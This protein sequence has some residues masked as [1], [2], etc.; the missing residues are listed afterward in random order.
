M[1][2]IIL[3]LSSVYKSILPV[4]HKHLTDYRYPLVVHYGSASSG[5]SYFIAQ[6]LILKALSSK[7]R[8]LVCRK[9][10]TS[11]RDSCWSL[12]KYLISFLPSE[13]YSINKSEFTIT[14]INESEIIFKGLDDSEKIKSIFDVSDIHCEEASEITESDFDQLTLRLRGTY[15][16]KQIYLSF[17]P[18]SKANW[19]YKRFFSPEGRKVLKSTQII[20]TTYK[21]N[22]TLDSVQISNIENL[23]LT[24]PNYY[25]IY[26]LGEFA[27]LDKLVFPDI[28]IKHIDEEEFYSRAGSSI[29]KF[30][31]LD[32]GFV[33]DPTALITGWYEPLKPV[34]NLYITH[35][36]IRYGVTNDLLANLLLQHSHDTK[37]YADSAEQKS[38][39]EIQKFGFKHIYSAKKGQGSVL[40]GIDRISRCNIII[41]GSC[42]NTIEEFKNYSWQK[43]RKSGEYLNI[44]ID[45]YN[46]CLVGDTL[47]DTPDG[48]IPIKDLVGKE[49]S[50]YAYD[51][52]LEKRVVA[53]FTNCRQ[54]FEEAEIWEIEFIDGTRMECT[55]NH[56]VLTSNRGYVMASELT[57]DDDVVYVGGYTDEHG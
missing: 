54:T 16:D 27:T 2:E 57:E 1:E 25:K 45:A 49:G 38:I 26:A 23:K 40:L 3:D 30:A 52:E 41:D 9:V 42:T 55:Y 46:H 4:Y 8:I 34:S 22:P 20:K 53:E 6:K 7:R 32:F 47:V 24:N 17:N 19:V 48:Q 18:I 31:G 5:K 56:P 13:Y 21:S 14:F 36:L 35:E 51:I 43:D 10:G 29:Y 12:Y 50:I 15:T 44:P 33:N 11:I 28:T 37:V 39:A